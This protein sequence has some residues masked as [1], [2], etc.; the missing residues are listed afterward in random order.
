MF[1]TSTLFPKL[2]IACLLFFPT[3]VIIFHHKTKINSNLVL[4]NQEKFKNVLSQ[5]ELEKTAKLVTVRIFSKGKDR[6]TG[7]SGVIIEK[8]N[9]AYLVITNNHVVKENDVAYYLQTHTG[10]VYLAQVIWQN[11]QNLIVNDLAILKFSSTA[12]YER[13]KVKNYP[14]VHQEQLVFASGFAVEKN[15]EQSKKMNCTWGN[16][17]MILDKPLMGGYQLGY[18]N[19]V[20]N[21]MSGGPI[22]NLQGELIGINGLGKYP[23]LGNPYVYQDGKTIPEKQIETMSELS[24]GIPTNYINQMIKEK[25]L[26]KEITEFKK[27]IRN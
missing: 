12:K 24:W 7:G 9:G 26:S 16:M 1:F 8:D 11:N 2:A 20:H 5:K 6:E 22:L 17:T 19:S 21:G 15:L 23:L 18:T 25:N 10:N 3:S 4:E 27:L 14:L 13:I